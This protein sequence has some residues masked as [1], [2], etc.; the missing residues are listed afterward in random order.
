[1]MIM[2][3]LHSVMMMVA[4]TMMANMMREMSIVM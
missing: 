1:M 3:N 4:N 2:G